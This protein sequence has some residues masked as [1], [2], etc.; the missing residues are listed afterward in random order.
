MPDVESYRFQAANTWDY[1]DYLTSIE[2]EWPEYTDFRAYLED[3]FEGHSCRKSS[4]TGHVH[5]HNVLPDNSFCT[6]FSFKA[7]QNSDIEG[8]KN[9]L[10][11]PTPGSRTRLVLV[12]LD[13]QKTIDQRVLNLLR[14]SFNIDP[15]FFWSLLG[16]DK[17]VSRQ[18]ESLSMS[19]MAIKI[20]RNCPTISGHVSVGRLPC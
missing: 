16:T 4:L 15:L 20:L 7:Q 1:I 13:N 8:L 2:E 10:S 19:Y 14:L 18:Q 5:F 6:P 3:N 11:N 17:F 12:G 9:A